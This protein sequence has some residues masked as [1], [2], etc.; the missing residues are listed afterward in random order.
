MD[1]NMDPKMDPKMDQFWTNLGPQIGSPNGPIW[2]QF[3]TS[4][5]I[6]FIR[7]TALLGQYSQDS[8]VRTVFSGQH[9]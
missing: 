3:G 7:R 8:I 1:P 2:D 9:C 6:K 4:K 5:W